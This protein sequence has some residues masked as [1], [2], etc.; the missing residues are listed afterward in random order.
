MRNCHPVLIEI[1]VSGSI[2]FR[3]NIKA[4]SCIQIITAV[5]F[6]NIENRIVL[7]LLELLAGKSGIVEIIVN[8][9]LNS[10]FEIGICRYLRVSYRNFGNYISQIKIGTAVLTFN[11]FLFLRLIF[12][13][14]SCSAG[15][16]LINQLFT[17]NCRRRTVFISKSCGTVGCHFNRVL[18][19][20]LIF[21]C[22]ISCS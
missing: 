18:G 3:K 6:N 20:Q 14:R 22:S 1:K 16:F 15:R 12:L 7:H 9:A 2:F 10:L 21:N 19:C 4:V 17:R 8:K 13:S 11:I 5:Q